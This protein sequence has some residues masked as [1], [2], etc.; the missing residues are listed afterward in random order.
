MKSKLPTK[1]ESTQLRLMCLVLGLGTLLLYLPVRQYDLVA[2]D[3]AQYLAEN[4]VVQAGL[5]WS[6]VKWAF[7]SWY[8]CHWHPLTWLSHMLDCQLFGADA[9]AHHFVNVLFHA[10]NVVLFLIVWYRLTGLL[11]PAAIIAALFAWHPLRVESVAWVSERKDVLS[12]FFWVLTVGAYGRYVHRR[13]AADRPTMLSLFRGRDA[14]LVLFFFALGLMSKPMLVTLP[15]LL[16]LLDYW[17]L[18]RLSNFK[19]SSASL[20]ALLL[21][22]TPLFILAAASCGVTYLA[23]RSVTVVAIADFPWAPR[24]GNV[25]LAYAGYLLKML[26]PVDLAAY[27]P[28][29]SQVSL[30][31]VIV[32]A[33][34]LVGITLWVIWRLKRQPYLFVGWFWYLGTL[35][36]VIGLVQIGGQS[37]ADRYT[38]VPLLGI[39]L[40]LVHGGRELSVRYRLNQPVMAGITG[41]ILA[42]CILVTRHQLPFWRNSEAMF[43]RAVNVTE[44]NAET[45]SGLACALAH[46][47]RNSE[48]I[49]YFQ[50]A[51]QMDPAWAETHN[52][53]AIALAGLGRSE[54]ALKQYQEAV[55]LK[56]QTP[57]FRCNLGIQLERAGRF[58][59]AISCYE[60][61]LRLDPKSPRPHYL[62]GNVQKNQ[63]RLKDAIEQYQAALQLDPND[64]D[65]LLALAKLLAS[66]SDPQ[67]RNGVEAVSLAERANIL[68][69]GQQPDVLD[70]LAMAYAEAGRFDLAST[71]VKNAINLVSTARPNPD[72][73]AM[74]ERQRLYQSSQPYHEIGTNTPAINQKIRP[75]E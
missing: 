53:F 38:Y 31:R 56:P 33:I 70:I 54:E 1:V 75:G 28:M 15:F 71:T 6:G 11:W 73:L 3:D 5:T 14:I 42:G 68:S 2:L 10:A 37:M 67:V 72:L 44:A 26:W 7:T 66:D 32:A 55:R 20:L 23:Q 63:G 36:P 12:T 65:S 9:G 43:R 40:M 52:D 58:A 49:P 25:V 47:G 51:L 4:R 60:E 8:A 46:Q 34:A 18:Q 45:Q 50:A 69:D 57:V 41:L 22:K 30:P 59:E 35:V 29:P 17:P 19:L 74:Q 27:Y 24:L 61:A 62:L 21:E 16:L 64:L 48:A 13:K 39:F